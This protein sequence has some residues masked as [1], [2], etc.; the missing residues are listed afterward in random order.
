MSGLIEELQS[1][2]DLDLERMAGENS[3]HE[4]VLITGAWG[5]ALTIVGRYLRPMDGLD[6]SDLAN[7][8]EQMPCLP[9]ERHTFDA[10]AKVC[11]CGDLKVGLAT[12]FPQVCLYS[13]VTD[14]ERADRALEMGEI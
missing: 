12:E 10:G 4:R 8:R 14:D 1:A 13:P 6:P 3:G 2:R 11:L 7:L 9:G 5:T